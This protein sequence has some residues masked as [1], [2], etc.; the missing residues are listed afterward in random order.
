MSWFVNGGYPDNTEFIPAPEAPQTE[1][2]R[3]QWR[4]I[5]GKND[6]YPWFDLLPEI[7]PLNVDPV[8][9]P[10]YITI[11]DMDTP[12]EDFA[13]NG[14]AILEPSEAPVSEELNGAWCVNLTHPIAPDGKWQ[15]IKE[16]NILKVCD[17]LFTIVKVMHNFTS[18]STGTVSVYAEAMFYQLA[19]PFI[20]PI[21]KDQEIRTTSCLDAIQIGMR[22]M[23][24]HPEPGQHSYSFS[25]A[26]SWEWE[27]PYIVPTERGMTF[28]E[29]LIGSGGITDTKGGELYRD[30]FYFSINE[31]MENAKDDAFDIRIGL[32]LCGIR[33]TVDVS[34]FCSYFRA[35]DNFGSWWAVAWQPSEFL[36]DNFPHNIIRSQ[37]FSYDEFD[38]DRLI[39]DGMAEFRRN[40]MPI[41]SYEID[42]AE[43]R[44]NPDFVEQCPDFEYKV[45]NSGR[46]FDI[47]FGGS[48][49]MKI[50]ATETDGIT[51]EVTK[52]TF[53]STRSFTRSANYPPTVVVEPEPQD[54]LVLVTDSDGLF[55]VDSDGVQLVETIHHGGES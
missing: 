16:R 33:R 34:T 51:G 36:L 42:L 31:R 4:I 18:A 37:N 12:K 55:I 19:D 40:A 45:G 32:N 53:G 1:Y 41:I 8:K 10:R 30:N 49:T 43:V 20:F 13:G 5:D 44:N 26:S 9:Q 3:S 15:Y 22:A 38:Y 2:P 35:Y 46:I 6:G 27:A 47:R 50:T 29:Y 54:G 21:P 7:P 11:Y 14:I 17:Q 24:Y 52:V 48:L 39:Q 23:Y 28:V 25:G